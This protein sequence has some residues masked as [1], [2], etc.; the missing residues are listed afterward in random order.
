MKA[1]AGLGLVTM[2]RNSLPGIG[3]ETAANSNTIIGGTMTAIG[4]MTASTMTI[5]RNEQLTSRFSA[6]P[7]PLPL[8]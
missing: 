4:T 3:T 8:S 5:A 2:E 1:L 7:R 6:S